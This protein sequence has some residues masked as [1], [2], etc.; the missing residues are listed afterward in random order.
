[1][2]ETKK[3]YKDLIQEAKE[4][5]S[6][7]L[8]LY[9]ESISLKNIPDE[10]FELIN[11]EEL[12]IRNIEID[13]ISPKI[14]NLTK[15][16]TLDLRGQISKFPIEL[17]TLSSLEEFTLNSIVLEEI[18]QEINKWDTL[19]YLN[20]DGCNNLNKI[21]GLPKN[22]TYL[23]ISRIGYS[24]LP[25][26]IFELKTLWKLVAGD[27]KLGTLPEWLF[28]MNSLLALF[29]RGNNLK[30]I[31]PSIKKL[32]NLSDLWLAN[33]SLEEIPESITSLTN[34]QR[35]VISRNLIKQLPL[36]FQNLTNLYDLDLGENDLS[37]FP[38]VLLELKELTKIRLGN[39]SRN[40]ALLYKSNTIKIIP[41]EI[42]KL[43]KL[44]MLDL[45]RLPIE[46]IPQEIIGK[47]YGSIK[48]FLQSIIDSEKEEY[49]CEAKMVIVGRGH[50]GKTVLTSK[51]TNPN[52]SLTRTDSTTAISILK[53]PFTIDIHGLEGIDKFNFT[54]WDFGGQEKYDA[55]HQLFITNRSLYLFITEARQE[56][57]YLDFYY[58]LNTIRLFSDNSPVVVVLSK[59][60]ERKK[61]LPE[62]VYKEEFKN[63][64]DF[65][66]VSCANGYEYTIQGLKKVIEEATKLLPQTK[67]KLSNRWIDIRNEL[68]NLSKEVDYIDYDKYIN[69]CM[70]HKLNK[71]QADFLSQYLNDLGSIIHHQSDLL[72][73]QTVFV[74]TEWCVDGMYKV[75]DDEIIFGNHG[76]FT[77]SDLNKI[78]KEKRF[79]NKQAEL[80][81]LMKEYNLCFEL[82][83]GSG[84]IAPEM[85]PPDKPKALVWDN[86]KCM[87]FE[88][89]YSFMPAGILSRF[90]VKCHSFIQGEFYW[91]YGV[92]LEYDKTTA[93]VEEDYINSRIKISLQG[94][95]KK[96][97]LS[98]IRMYIEEVHKDLDKANKLSFEEMVPCNCSECSKSQTP[99]F[100]KF[101]VLKRH[102][103]KSKNKITCDESSEEVNISFL[104]NDLDVTTYSPPK[105]MTNK[106]LRD[107]IYDIMTS[108]LEHQIMYKEGNVN[109]WR[110]N[111]YKEPKS[112]IEIQQYIANSLDIYCRVHGI[113]LGREVREANG[114]VD[115][116]FTYTNE[117]N[118]ILKV[119]VEIK[120]A[121][122]QHI[123][124]AIGTQLPEY[125]R[126]SGTDAG[127]YFVAWL[128]NET[129]TE[130]NK[131]KN[132]M[133]LFKAIESNN[134]EPNNISIKLINCTKRTSPSR[135]R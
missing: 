84:Y 17:M 85:L 54:I 103:Q 19:K 43:S 93:L 123:E 82:R 25:E 75:L 80:I 90:I 6:K 104:I 102:E 62:S 52:Y 14:K 15:L 63:I 73:K 116:L 51:L 34:L 71:T 46:N 70:K 122:H 91:K 83:D 125:M 76:K 38:Q 42:V 13:I 92:V 115:L 98:A 12:T 20:L 130:P 18:P 107:Y 23:N 33:N 129:F 37:E 97:L 79:E 8:A 126:S 28:E 45:R 101:N 95:S 109:F 16:R 127:I 105:F 53:N 21:N 64:V 111:E 9:D 66:N 124:T 128:K 119:C 87:R 61:L 7:N 117:D 55:T 69:I 133:E 49:L 112:E 44:T 100:Y 77:N 3:D 99:H 58:W 118:N 32:T 81:R 22:L 78:W 50:V 26:I 10:I 36:S 40:E 30:T 68:D 86:T 60:D 113:H 121:N 106:E 1:M 88:Y 39:N 96:A 94:N 108:E 57:N 5:N 56:S 135:I 2:E 110:S 35:L 89:R 65:V 131:Y 29:L 24:E 4:N 67:Q 120:K 47:G 31:S 11:L 134:K 74:N 114:N 48:D 72:L 59:L 132:E 41:T 27:L